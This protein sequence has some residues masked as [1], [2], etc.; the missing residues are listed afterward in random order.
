MAGARVSVPAR[1]L[2]KGEE[3][4]LLGLIHSGG[5]PFIDDRG[6]RP[7]SRASKR[8]RR[9]EHSPVLHRAVCRPEEEDDD[10]HSKR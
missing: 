1:N 3:L 8:R 4:G 10:L 9:I 6:R 5:T 2:G 7:S